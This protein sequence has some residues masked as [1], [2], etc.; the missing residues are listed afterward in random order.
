MYSLNATVAALS[1]Y[2]NFNSSIIF[3]AELTSDPAIAGDSRASTVLLLTVYGIGQ[4]FDLASTV[5]S[6]AGSGLR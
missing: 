3:I 6:P 2:S 5:F 1:V 4:L